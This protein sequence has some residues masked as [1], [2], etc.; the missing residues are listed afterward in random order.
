MTP[1]PRLHFAICPGNLIDGLG[2]PPKLGQALVISDS[3]IQWAGPME[4]LESPDG[5]MAGRGPLEILNYP[6]STLLPGLIDCHTHTNMPGNGRRGEDVNQD[7][8]D[9]KLL[10]SA[11]NVAT[12]LRSG[13]TTV[14]DCGAWHDTAFSLK[15]GVEQGLVDGPRM[16]VSGRPVTTT[17]GHL[18]FMGGEADGVE[19][20]RRQV[21]LLIKQG[22]DFIK[23][24]ASGGSTA[25]S[26]PYRPSLTE[27]EIRILVEEAHNR[28]KPVAAHCR[29]TAAINNAVSAGVDMVLHCAFYES[30]QTYHWDQETAQRL[31]DSG[32]WV[33][34]TLNGGRARRALLR[35]K[36]NEEGLTPEEQTF[37][38]NGNRREKVNLEHFGKL[39]GMGVK[40][41][42]GSDC[43][44]GSY[45][46][47]DFQGELIALSD[48]GLTPVEAILAGTR[49]AAAAMGILDQTGTI[50][51]GKQADLLVVHGD[52]TKNLEDLRKVEAVVHNGVLAGSHLGQIQPGSA[53]SS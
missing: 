14:C 30:D 53:N 31:A 27:P 9:I 2:G 36:Q 25:T 5:P 15:Q 52:P 12:A 42:G 48:A 47:G 21:R 29:C 10:R 1:S 20:V 22:A 35:I 39:I 3:K 7:S 40:M 43:G 11:K 23:V 32:T 16:M 26:D 49:D 45:P 6:M 18:W 24:V 44:W 34:P 8:D 4:Q 19:G 38:D 17:G 50:E 33:N 51:P 28:G 41:I 13:V 46:F 37:L